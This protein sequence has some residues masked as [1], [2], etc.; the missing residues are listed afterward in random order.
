MNKHINMKANQILVCLIIGITFLWNGSSYMSW[1]YNLMGIIDANGISVNSDML[2]DVYS[3]L[4]QVLGALFTVLYI[5]ISDHDFAKRRTMFIVMMLLQMITVF[6]SV[7][8]SSYLVCLTAGFVM[9]IFNGIVNALYFVLL[10]IL[11]PAGHRGIVFGLGYSIGSI[12]SWILSLVGNGN[13]LKSHSVLVA[14][15]L[16][17]IVSIALALIT[18]ENSPKLTQNTNSEPCG[19]S[20]I[21]LTGAMVLLLCTTKGIAFYFPMADISNGTISLELSRAFYAI[22][23]IIAGLLNDYRRTYGG[24]ACIAALMFPFVLLAM[25]ASP[26]YSFYTWIL[27]YVFIAF[28]NVFRILIFADLSD[29]S[30]KGLYLAPMG[31]MWGRLGD[32]VGSAIGISLSAKSMALIVLGSIMFAVTV[33][34]AFYIF[35]RVYAPTSIGASSEASMTVDEKMASYSV[36]HDLSAREKEVLPLILEGH[37]NSEISGMIFVSENT[38]KFH[39]RNILKKTGCANRQELAKSFQL[40]KPY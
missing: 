31:L 2:F 17:M 22:G 25:T 4:M 11:V 34:M 29:R 9:N 28:Y 12:G 27:S 32:A 40:Y 3:Y 6:P 21:Y 7:L 24:I 23:L 39:V 15:I 33:V 13:F 37:S 18:D 36:Y 10:A 20:L 30:P 38:V 16:L 14:Y 26:E 19:R 35:Q 5:R 8:S 1:L